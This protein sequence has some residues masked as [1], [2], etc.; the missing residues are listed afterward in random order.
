LKEEKDAVVVGRTGELDQQ[1]LAK[2]KKERKI[3]DS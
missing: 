1:D 3:N 2:R